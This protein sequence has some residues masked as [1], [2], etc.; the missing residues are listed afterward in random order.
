MHIIGIP[1]EED[2]ESGSKALLEKT[3]NISKLRTVTNSIG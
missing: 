1:V 3:E 2:S